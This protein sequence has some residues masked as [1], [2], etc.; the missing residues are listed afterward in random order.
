MSS[1]H[2]NA[3]YAQAARAIVAANDNLDMDDEPIVSA[4]EEDGAFVQAWIWVRDADVE[5]D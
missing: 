3:Q 5:G 1:K 2:T 4:G